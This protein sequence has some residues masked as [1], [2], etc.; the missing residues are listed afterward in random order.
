MCPIKVQKHLSLAYFSEFRL[1]RKLLNILATHYHPND[2]QLWRHLSTLRR[3]LRDVQWHLSASETGRQSPVDTKPQVAQRTMWAAPPSCP[4]LW[5]GTPQPAPRSP[6]GT[7]AGVAA[8]EGS[9]EGVLKQSG[10]GPGATVSL[11]PCSLPTPLRVGPDSAEGTT[12]GRPRANSCSQAGRQAGTP[13]RI[14][15]QH[16]DLTCRAPHASC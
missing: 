13:S 6:G 11:W 5:E 8:R 1:S 2:W 12:E 7:W 14:R 16:P 9:R 15:G 4:G 3:L 10:L